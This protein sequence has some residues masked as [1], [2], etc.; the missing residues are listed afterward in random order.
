[1]TTD[2]QRTD[3]ERTAQAFPSIPDG[4]LG[5]AMPEWLRTTPD[6]SQSPQVARQVPP[7]NT[8]TIDPATLVAV[9]DLPEWLQA[10]ARRGLPSDSHVASSAV[11]T[12]RPLP[13]PKAEPSLTTYDVADERF[14]VQVESNVVTET[15]QGSEM[16][17][18]GRVGRFQVSEGMVI[19]LLAIV[20]I[21]ALVTL[22]LFMSLI[23]Q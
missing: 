6:W 8:S 11:M 5:D 3:S 20:G 7:P 2:Q 12:E 17:P 22:I 15:P 16:P 4:G 1:M 21:L 23:F 14:D 18:I 10:M 9:D 19:A 13:Q